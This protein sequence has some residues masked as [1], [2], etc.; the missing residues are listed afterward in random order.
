MVQLTAI[1]YGKRPLP[2]SKGLDN[3]PFLPDLVSAPVPAHAEMACYCGA[4]TRHKGA[5]TSTVRVNTIFTRRH[6][7]IS[8]TQYQEF[9]STKLM[10]IQRSPTIRASMGSGIDTLVAIS[11]NNKL[12]VKA[13]KTVVVAN[14]DRLTTGTI[15]LLHHLILLIMYNCCY[16]RTGSPYSQHLQNHA[17]GSSPRLY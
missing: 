2:A 4:N 11:T 15:S 16:Q 1:L 12:R 17:T 7:L 6:I 14:K 9:C 5:N 13:P 10:N 8:Q 3:I